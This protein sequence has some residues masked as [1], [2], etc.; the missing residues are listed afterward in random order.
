MDLKNVQ[1]T[2]DERIIFKRLLNRAKDYDTALFVC[3]TAAKMRNPT[4]REQF[5][6]YAIERA[7]KM[8]REI[9]KAINKERRELPEGFWSVVDAV[10]LAD[11]GLD[12][13][14]HWSPFKIT[15]FESAFQRLAHACL[16]RAC[17][18]DLEL[19]ARLTRKDK[20]LLGL[21]LNAK[22][23]RV[24]DARDIY[25]GQLFAPLQTMLDKETRFNDALDVAERHNEDY[26]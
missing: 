26:T 3:F 9:W 16:L 6:S 5:I 7:E 11:L 4:T 2:H 1:L 8:Q 18:G 17:G 13:L 21:A 12:D 23:I 20:R 25:D 22:G 19:M 10:N 15:A 14:K 24:T